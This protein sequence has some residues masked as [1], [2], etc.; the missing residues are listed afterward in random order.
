MNTNGPRGKKSPVRRLPSRGLLAQPQ[1]SNEYLPHNKPSLTYLTKYQKKPRHSSRT[2]V[3]PSNGLI[4]VGERNTHVACQT[5]EQK[6]RQTNQRGTF[7]FTPIGRV[8]RAV[9]HNSNHSQT[10][11]VCARSMLE[12]STMHRAC[13]RENTTM[14][15]QRRHENLDK[16]SGN[17]YCGNAQSGTATGIQEGGAP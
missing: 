3:E 9:G 4:I 17:K 11:R 13:R 1:K 16:E 2:R 12:P 8:L 15:S 5:P 6:T 7:T 14:H 10:G